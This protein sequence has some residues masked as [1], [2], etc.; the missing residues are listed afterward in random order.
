MTS[1]DEGDRRGEGG[2]HGTAPS[3]RRA[4]LI[5]RK[6]AG[7]REQGA[8]SREQRAEITLMITILIT[9]MIT[10]MITIITI[11]IM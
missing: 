3:S 4:D 7:S 5:A 2:L 1:C 6:C 8:E 10:I 11:T 9:I